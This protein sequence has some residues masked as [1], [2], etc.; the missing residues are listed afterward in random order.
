MN[1]KNLWTIGGVLL[2]ASIVLTTAFAGIV[3][4]YTAAHKIDSDAARVTLQNQ[5]LQSVL[6]KLK[7]ESANKESLAISLSQKENLLPTDLNAVEFMDLA[8][9]LADNSGVKLLQLSIAPPQR[10]I[11]AAQVVRSASVT[12]ALTAV[13]PGSLYVSDVV[14]SVSGSLQ[15]V[16]DF[17]QAIRTSNRYTLIF[18]V[19]MPDQASSPGSASVVDLSAQIFMLKSK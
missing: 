13:A 10:F 6:N 1:N 11:G 12:R 8:K 2:M 19:N 14:F 7:S 3:P 18:K 9:S 5:A 4:T 16:A 15:Q 17:A